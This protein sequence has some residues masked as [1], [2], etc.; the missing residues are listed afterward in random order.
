M[1]EI[2]EPPA[3]PLDLR[4][5]ESETGAARENADRRNEALSVRVNA[6]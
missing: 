2:S 1:R 4:S 6:T 3:D 5:A